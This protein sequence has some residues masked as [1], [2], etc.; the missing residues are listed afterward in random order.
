MSRRVAREYAIQFLFS[1]DFNKTDD[2]ENQ[3][4]EFLQHRDE[5][6]E[7]EESALNK[8]SKDYAVEAIKGSLQ[9]MEE[10]DKLIEFHT[11]GWKKERIAKVDLAILRLAIYE[12]VFNNEVPDSVAANE[13]IELAK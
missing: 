5:H 7:E 9:H 10:I 6:R 11:T 13:A 4:I 2:V 3:I 1:L 12:I 8:S